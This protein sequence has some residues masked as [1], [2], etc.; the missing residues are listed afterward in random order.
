MR[1]AGRRLEEF[2]RPVT[3]SIWL[4]GTYLL[5]LWATGFQVLFQCWRF[6]MYNV[7]GS[8]TF[9]T[10]AVHVMVLMTAV[11]VGL[12][13]LVVLDGLKLRRRSGEWNATP[14]ASWALAFAALAVIQA[15]TTAID[16]SHRIEAV[17]KERAVAQISAAREHVQD[18]RFVPA[19]AAYR[20]GLGW[21]GL[22]VWWREYAWML[23]AHPDAPRDDHDWIERA[24][25]VALLI[26]HG[27]FEFELQAVHAAWCGDFELA[28]R[29]QLQAVEQA[30]EGGLRP[31]VRH[32]MR[33]RLELYEAGKPYIGWPPY[34]GGFPERIR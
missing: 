8:G 21:Y 9:P 19:E 30:S 14:R 32:A 3:E 15:G 12:L 17:R 33:E 7:Y 11:N 24:V 34:P 26:P 10:A 5:L 13:G 25:E 2:K 23:I 28:M 31:L 4:P 22:R 29:H 6:L 20:E 27:P 16:L 1:I 18:G